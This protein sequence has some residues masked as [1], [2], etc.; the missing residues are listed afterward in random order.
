M[1]GNGKLDKLIREPKIEPKMVTSL[2]NDS[3]FTYDISKKLLKIA[4][5]LWIDDKEIQKLGDV[6]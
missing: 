5:T 6:L 3:A 4:N 2:I 1:I